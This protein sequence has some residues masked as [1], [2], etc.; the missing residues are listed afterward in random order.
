MKM[1][2]V[3]SIS[4]CFELIDH[5]GMLDN[6]RQHSI[7]V[8]RVADTIITNLRLPPG[9]KIPRKNLVLAGALLH[10]IAKTKCLNG[11]CRHSD[12]GQLICCHHGY[13]EVGRIVGSHVILDAYTPEKYERG[14]FGPEEIVYY[15]DKRV[16]HDKIVSLAERLDYIIERYSGNDTYIEK[17]I[18]ENFRY[19]LDLERLL[20]SFLPFSPENLAQYVE[21]NPLEIAVAL[22]KEE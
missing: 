5:Y 19:C 20:F 13:P 17:R 10:D 4:R 22:Q 3:P 14:F 18:R 6:I 7:I 15:A 9:A 2:A 11:S 16:N 21:Q 12:E 1:T 8:T